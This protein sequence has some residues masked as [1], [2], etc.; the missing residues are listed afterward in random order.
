MKIT[1]SDAEKYG[2][3]LTDRLGEYCGDVILGIGGSRSYGID[4]GDFEDDG[5]II[6][7]VGDET[8]I[9]GKTADGLD[10]A[11]RRYANDISIFGKSKDTVYHEGQRIESLTLFG[12][13]VSEYSVVYDSGSA[14]AKDAALEFARLIAYAC[15]AELNV[16][17][18]IVSD[19][20]VR[21]SITDDSGLGEN[22]FSYCE[23]NGALIFE[24]ANSESAI[25]AV[26]YFF[27][28]ECFWDGITLGEG[29]LKDQSEL[30][31][32]LGICKRITPAF[33]SLT[34]G[35][36]D[37]YYL[38]SKRN[39]DCFSDD[40]TEDRLRGQIFRYYKRCDT[41]GDKPKTV[42]I[43]IGDEYC[44]CSSCQDALIDEK[45]TAA[46][47]ISL[48][49]SLASAL[50]DSC[51]GLSIMLFAD[52][53]VPAPA[54]VTPCSSVTVVLSTDALCSFH[55]LSGK[56]CT[57]DINKA[58]SESLPQ[59]LSSSE[60]VIVFLSDNSD[61]LIQN[62]ASEKLYNDLKHL[63]SLGVKN[64]HM[65]S[66]AVGLGLQSAD[67]RLAYALNRNISMTHL[68]YEERLCDALSSVYGD[69]WVY[70]R[71]YISLLEES[72]DTSLC[73]PTDDSALTFDA[74]FYG[75]NYG[76]ALSF[77]DSFTSMACSPK[78]EEA[79]RTLTCH[80]YYMGCLSTYYDSYYSGNKEKVDLLCEQY[81]AILS[82]LEENGF[83]IN[84][85]KG[86]AGSLADDLYDAAWHD[87]KNYRDLLYS[88]DV[89]DETALLEFCDRVNENASHNSFTLAFRTDT[90]YSCEVSDEQKSKAAAAMEERNSVA[91]YA[92]IDLF[93][94]GGDLI[95]GK[96]HSKE[97]AFQSIKEAVSMIRGVHQSVPTFF[98]RGNH[99]D[100]SWYGYEKYGKT[101]DCFPTDTVVTTDEW[102]NV[103][104]NDKYGVFVTDES[105]SY[106]YFDHEESKIRVLML[107]TSD[108]PYYD[109]G[110]GSYKY[111]A[112]AGHGIRQAQL[113]FMADA[114]MF[115]DKGEDASE[116]A[117]LVI[118]HVP[119]E[120][121][122]T[123]TAK[124]RFGGLDAA[125]RN[126][127]VFLRLLK[128]YQRGTAFNESRSSTT[129]YGD[130]GYVAGN[131]IDPAQDF[132][133][134]VCADFS[135]NGPGEVIGIIT[136]HTHVNNY[137]NEV[138]YKSY[139][140]SVI[141][142]ELSYG[143]SYFC[144]G[145]GGMSVFTVER[146]GDGNGTI[147][148]EH[149]GKSTVVRAELI[150]DSDNAAATSDP[151]MFDAVSSV[152]DTGSIASGSYSV[153]YSQNR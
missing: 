75:D 13:D 9:F 35:E 81:D 118:S 36:L 28:E 116:W 42:G 17:D 72:A 96:N 94:H 37:V 3:F 48:A 82:I 119:I 8:V 22:G 65:P 80:I 47:A 25:D 138:G 73:G 29:E 83:D 27:E 136:G 45:S 67:T 7:T 124:Y 58:F 93:V 84:N 110:E 1:S 126:F 120:T 40:K 141:Y 2:E 20:Y 78:Q 38:S 127:Y 60:N 95:N 12:R 152:P 139:T 39:I 86:F 123:A 135:V 115:T 129:N 92:D 14:G 112:Y 98:V 56:N 33:E 125:G 85:V 113:Q 90:H 99:D 76:T 34:T 68:E 134:S 114:M 153:K 44:Q 109:N 32:P 55:E 70:V 66:G 149:M 91:K 131:F 128:A 18:S 100:N 103:I 21:F 46:T 140:S 79:C 41:I 144:V 133:Y 97:L 87:W 11:C 57:G 106:G 16:S 132:A 101:Y 4:L 150:S 122:K 26:H 108:V 15:G 88:G 64:V 71:E 24:A 148:V 63:H 117:I 102:R 146:N 69:G 143:Y 62:Y 111:G 61:S 107:D 53:T 77:A 74:G 52:G 121:M 54:N 147:Y 23:N 6:K 105:G 49:N 137:S 5:Y 89:P 145:G 151:T 51:P 10:L 31:I 104:G 30:D 50:A 59:W 43:L 130:G 142:P 19:S